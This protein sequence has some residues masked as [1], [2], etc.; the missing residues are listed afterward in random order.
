MTA[1]IVLGGVAFVAYQW[2]G[3]RGKGIGLRAVPV[4]VLLALVVV[5]GLV[6]GGVYVFRRRERLGQ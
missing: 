6:A 5:V 4:E 1:A 2:S 3:G